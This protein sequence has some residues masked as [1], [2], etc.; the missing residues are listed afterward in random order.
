MTGRPVQSIWLNGGLVDARGPH[1]NVTDRGFQLG[2][3]L[4]ETARARRGIVIELDEHL[5][6]LRA[7]CAVLGLNLTVDDE[8]LSDGISELLAAQELD[9]SGRDGGPVGDAA[10]RITATRGPLE[11]RGLLP[12]GFEELQATVAIQCWPYLAVGAELLERGVRA[13][14]S[15]IRRDSGSPLSGIKTTSRA[16]YVYARLEAERAGADDALFLTLDGAISEATAANLFVVAGKTLA[17]PPLSAAILA[18]TTR[19]WL[20]AQAERLG[21]TP[22]E[23]ELR[24]DRARGGRR[25]IPDRQRGRHRAALEP[26]RPAGR[27]RPAG[28]ARARDPGGARGVDRRDVDGCPPAGRTRPDPAVTRDEL[29]LRTRQ[30]VDEGERLQQSPSLGALQVWL[31][32]S[33]ELLRSAWGTMDRYHLSWLMVGKSR[34][35]VR[36]RPMQPEE[37]ADYVREVAGQKTAALRM[38]LD[39]AERRNM[40]FVG[41]TPG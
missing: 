23:V 4:F 7:G 40:P 8:Q 31:Q 36:G 27:R 26:R 11:R 39:A 35:I 25:G 9:A 19:T 30:L 41:E 28:T 2:D 22:V 24:P 1:L 15:S 17:T 21:L 13:I 32:L 6:R 20:L 3:G 29:I 18:G 37:E 34:S 10:I 5:E 33:D 14:S 16:D 38:S 12:A